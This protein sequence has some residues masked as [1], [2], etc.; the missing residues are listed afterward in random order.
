MDWRSG[1]TVETVGYGR[2][3]LRDCDR[4]SILWTLAFGESPAVA[5]GSRSFRSVPQRSCLD[6]ARIILETGSDG[7]ACGRFFVLPAQR[8]RPVSTHA[9]NLRRSAG[10]VPGVGEETRV[11]R[12]EIGEIGRASCRERV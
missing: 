2:L 12:L 9:E 7:R 6:A 3:S 4:A 5:R 10:E 1:P 8:T 11:D